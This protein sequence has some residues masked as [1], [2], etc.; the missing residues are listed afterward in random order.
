M[1]MHLRR[2]IWA[3]CGRLVRASATLLALRL[4]AAVIGTPA[5]SVLGGI[6]IVC[7]GLAWWAR[8]V[9]PRLFAPSSRHVGR[10]AAPPSDDRH[11]AFAQALA[12]VAARYVAE[13]EATALARRQ[14]DDQP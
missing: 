13:C 3:I 2:R 10:R 11:L 5:A 14:E 7:W 9:E 4:A 8:V 6:G 12:L 1:T